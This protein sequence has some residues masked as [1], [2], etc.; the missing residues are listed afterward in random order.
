MS[1]KSFI[2]TKFDYDVSDLA[3][4]VDEQKDVLLTRQVS[5][6]R[7][8]QLIATQTGIKGSEAL[9]LLDDSIV[10]QA[11]DC[12]MTASGDTVFT[13]RNIQV[14]KIGFMKGFCNSDLEGLWTQL[15][16]QA[17]AM[18]EDK[19]LPFEAQITDYLLKLHARELDKLIWR[20][21]KSTGTGNLQWI[22]G[23]TQFLTVAN[24]CIDLNTGSLAS[25]TV[26][27]TYEAFMDAYEAM[28][29]VNADLTENPD[30]TFF[31][32]VE[33][34]TKLRR[35][36][37]NLNLY[38]K[39]VDEDAFTQ[40]LFG[41]T[42]TIEAVPGLNG[43]N[44]FYFGKKSEFIFG[45]DLSS[46]FDNFELWYSQDDDKLYLRSKFRAGTQVPFLNQIGVFELTGSPSV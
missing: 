17:G 1:L 46:D 25:L 7:T 9:K 28:Q 24:G 10:Y 4:Y 19:Q 5:E 11:G 43:T 2:K 20:G 45:T 33:T 27:N 40:F 39:G 13:D 21:N 8:L 23:F 15:A 32:G 31:C 29:A 12:E 3:P 44:S 6:A 26:A 35:N 38:A 41:T 22:N 34:L 37:I 42:K 18:A 16:L 36:M 30:A 14:E